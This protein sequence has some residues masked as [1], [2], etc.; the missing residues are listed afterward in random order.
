[1]PAQTSWLSDEEITEL[2]VDVLGIHILRRLVEEGQGKKSQG[3][4]SF[5][6][7]RTMQVHQSRRSPDRGMSATYSWE[8]MRA[9]PAVGRAL[10]EAW[11]WLV[12]EELIAL[13]PVALAVSDQASPDPYFVT[14]WGAE[15]AA[16][17]TRALDLTRAR[18]RLGLELHR[19]LR[20]PLGRLVRVGAFEEAAFVALREVEQRVGTLASHPTGRNGRLRGDKLMTAAFNEGG[21]LADP[22]AEPAEQQGQMNLF[23]GAFAAFRNPLG[24]RSVE[25]GDP[26][27]AAEVVL[28]ADLLMR[29]LD[30]IEDRLQPD[31]P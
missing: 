10:A 15:V 2:E 13:D 25:F 21:P 28:F 18:R 17:G 5:I 22:E 20:R 14:R 31:G 7:A 26:T 27:E 12:G 30:H 3:R 4:Q 16:E 24:H 11:E 1:M 23:K 8:A 9:E 6:E 29:Q 19:V